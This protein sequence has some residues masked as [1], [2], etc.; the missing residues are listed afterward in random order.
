MLK[1]ASF[2]SIR[3]SIFNKSGVESQPELGGNLLFSA[4]KLA[5]IVVHSKRVYIA[6]HKL[7]NSVFC[8]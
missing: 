1:S 4:V 6:I 8:L 2:I 3:F 5:L 7:L